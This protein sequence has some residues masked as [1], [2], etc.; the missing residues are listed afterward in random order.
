MPGT[1]V[2]VTVTNKVHAE[3]IDWYQITARA[4]IGKMAKRA[5]GWVRAEGVVAT[6]SWPF[7][8]GQLHRWEQQH[9][10]L[11]LSQRITKL[12]QMC[13]QR[14]L[15]F[16]SVIGVGAS[17][18]YLDTRGLVRTEWQIPAMARVMARRFLG[19][20]E[21]MVLANGVHVANPAAKPH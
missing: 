6:V 18:E 14:A 12:R 15:P 13:H 8:R 4:R 21:T 17:D 2:P 9:A 3:G 20:L 16:D 5:K 7:F 11:G 10:K 19:W 1:H